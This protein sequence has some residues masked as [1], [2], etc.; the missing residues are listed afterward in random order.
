MNYCYVLDCSLTM[1]WLFPDEE[2]KATLDLREQLT[3]SNAIVPAIWPIEVGN[4]LWSAEK[5]KRISPYQSTQFKNL[6]EQLPIEIDKKTSEIALG[7]ILECAREYKITVYD[8]CYLELALR[9]GTPL[10][11]LDKELAEAAQ[12]AG[13]PILPKI[14]AS[15]FIK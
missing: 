8:A 14:L 12:K 11:T 3:Q 15:S 7:L 9:I 10:A 5:K 1:S 6:L 13:I 2:S 4:I